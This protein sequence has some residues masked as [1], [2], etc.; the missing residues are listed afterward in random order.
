MIGVKGVENDGWRG[1]EYCDLQS[2]DNKW[3]L[4]SKMA[5]EEVNII[6]RVVYVEEGTNIECISYYAND[7]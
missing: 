7:H 3:K 5:E 2:Y 1:Y 6:I 4:V